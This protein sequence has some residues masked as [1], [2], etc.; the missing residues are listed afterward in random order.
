MTPLERVASTPKGQLK[1]RIQT[2]PASPLCVMCR[3][4]NPL[5]LAVNVMTTTNSTSIDG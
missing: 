3:H 4:G 2:S 5:R 1:I